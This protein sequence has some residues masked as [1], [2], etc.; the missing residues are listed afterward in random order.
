MG[1]MS[2]G[3][4]MTDTKQRFRFKK[5]WIAICPKC[6]NQLEGIDECGWYSS[7]N[8]IKACIKYG[9]IGCDCDE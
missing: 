9:T 8:E 7:K 1:R 6:G 3:E 4:E 2:K 5:V